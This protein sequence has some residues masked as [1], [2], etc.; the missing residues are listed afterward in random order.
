MQT[1]RIRRAAQEK[2]EKEAAE[3]AAR[4]EAE[5]E[6]AEKAAR[7]EAEREAA[8]KAAREEAGKEAAEKAASRECYRN[9]P[10]SQPDPTVF[11]RGN[12]LGPPSF[13]PG[14]APAVT[15]HRRAVGGERGRGVDPTARREAP[16]LGP[17]H[18]VDGVEA[19]L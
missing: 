11:S 12:G 19:V 6:A 5:R 13:S 1:N 14:N 7:E 9:G 15:V 4:E 10:L 16:L 2:A 8:E 18:R 3:K 17:C